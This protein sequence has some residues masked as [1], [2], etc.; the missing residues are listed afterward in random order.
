M[1]GTPVTLSLPS[2]DDVAGLD[3]AGLDAMLWELE[4]ARRKLTSAI[5]SV[6]DQCDRTG[7][8]L[9]DGHRTVKAWNS[10]ITNSSPAESSRRH[11]LA[12]S[13]RDLTVV[14][15]E[16]AAG[17]VGVDQVVELAFLH[18]NPR[19]ADQL[20]GSEQILLDAAKAL[21]FVD[22][23][24]VAKRWEQLADADGAH[25]DHELTHQHRNATLTQAGNGYAWST[26]HGAIQ[27][28]TMQSIFTAFCDAE[29]LTDWEITKAQY[30]D[31]ACPALMPRTDRQRRADALVAIFDTAVTANGT[32]KLAD[33]VVNLVMDNDQFEQYLREQIDGTPVQIDP[34]SVLDRRCE[35]IDGVPVDPRQAVALAIVGQVR[36]IVVNSAGV[37]TDAGRLR[38]LFN[39][40]LREALIALSPRCMWLGCTI[41]AVLSQIDHLQ[42]HSNGGFTD[43]ANGA[44]ACQHPNLFK[45]KNR[46][47]A[48]RQPDSTWQ[49]T[50]PDGTHLQVP[51]AVDQRDQQLQD[52]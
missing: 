28:T 47:T 11:K 1:N 40:P 9:A 44:I 41:R 42:P 29:F 48:R 30:G 5:V 32:G 31:A 13:L 21:E 50:R 23:R 33:P 25:R 3:G 10:A 49:L 17:T 16:L 39:G 15:D 36:R 38:R 34:A 26:S 14:G 43:A 7:H 8:Y 37:V 27:G 20:A 18:T 6:V 45:H 51:D 24:T 52:A 2:V 22:F 12:R 46:Y 4:V 35:T 19:C